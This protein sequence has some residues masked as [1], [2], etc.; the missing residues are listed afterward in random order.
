LAAVAALTTIW[1]VPAAFSIRT[2]SVAAGPHTSSSRCV[3]PTA[4]SR[5]RAL[6]TPTDMRSVTGA[7]AV[8]IGPS[9]RSRPLMAAALAH[10]RAA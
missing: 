6:C 5:K 10:A 1:L 7:A 3:R 2:T 9:S 4:N 8:A